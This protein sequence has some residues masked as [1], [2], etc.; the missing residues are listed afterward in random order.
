[1][2][3]VG[4]H[5]PYRACQSSFWSLPWTIRAFATHDLQD[6]VR[7]CEFTERT[8]PCE[9]L[10]QN[11]DVRRIIHPYT[12]NTRCGEAQGQTSIATIP[13]ANTSA[14]LVTVPTSHIISGAAH[15]PPCATEFILR[16]E[17]NWKS[18]KRA[19]P[20]RS[21]RMLD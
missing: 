1:M 16:T 12:P 18:V 15:P 8:L 14:S 13:N 20:L 4:R 21:T 11:S 17:G 7:G 9:N 5:I 2:P 10:R 3:T 19:R 6:N